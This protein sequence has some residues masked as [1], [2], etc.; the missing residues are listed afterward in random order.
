VIKGAY[1]QCNNISC[2]SQRVQHFRFILETLGVKGLDVTTLE[3]MIDYGVI[4]VFEDLFNLS[5]E[6]LTGSGFGEIESANW[7]KALKGIKTTPAK[8]LACLGIEGWGETMFENLFAK[9]KISG[10]VW[11]G[12][13]VEHAHPVRL[14]EHIKAMGPVRESTFLKEILEQQLFLGVLLAHVQ[15]EKEVTGGKLS[16]KSFCITGTLTKGRKEIQEDIKKA[17]GIVKDS[18]SKDLDYLVA[19][20]DCGSKLEKAKKLNI[21]TI[22]E[23]ELYKMM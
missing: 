3:K 21:K 10:S 20:D 14:L 17:G 12:E 16:G 23:S 22:L 7:I 18:V 8:L 19:G 6:I 1:L 5:I 15:L 9:S 13:L 2:S 11:V 4:V